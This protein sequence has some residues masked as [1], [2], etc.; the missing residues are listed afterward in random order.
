MRCLIIDDVH[1]VLFSLLEEKNID[2]DYLPDISEEEVKTK[3]SS[4]HIIVL[5]SKMKITSEIIQKAPDL[6]IIARV[7]AGLDNIDVRFAEKNR[8][9]VL[10]ANEGN[11][12]AVAEHTLG[13]ILG[14]LHKIIKSNSEI[15]DFIW[16][17]EANRGQELGAKTVGIF[18][19]GHMGKAVARRLSGF[20]CK[21]LAYDKYLKGFSDQYVREVTLKEF[22][23]KVQVAT[24]HIPLTQETFELINDEF[25]QKFTHPIYLI[26]TSRGKI[27]NLQHLIENIEN[28]KILG[29]GLDVLPNEQFS[30]YDEIE[31]E[32]LKK[33][34]F[35]D[36]VILTP[37]VAGWS[38]E[39]Y[40]KLSEVIG[41]KITD[42][43]E[44]KK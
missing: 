36:N 19:Y 16:E 44:D 17:R 3:I 41:T 10:S 22:F 18:G 33:L 27:I 29:A 43:L 26:N 23:E 13:L 39:S 2:Y 37:H 6:K 20:G 31:K 5:R 28:R 32:Q 9:T 42:S 24:F 21:V 25:I 4:Y 35:L 15:Q 8:I 38:V 14:L 30:T 34:N 11:S 7:G 1:P 40:R 12:D